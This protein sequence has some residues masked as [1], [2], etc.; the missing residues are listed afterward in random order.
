MSVSIILIGIVCF[1]LFYGKIT[2]MPFVL[3]IFVLGIVFS[4]F[5]KKH[6]HHDAFLAIDCFAQNSKLNAYHPALKMCVAVGYIFLSIA[7]NSLLVSVFLMVTMTALTIYT[8]RMSLHHYV[9]IF[10]IPITFIL[11]SA[12]AILLEI[13]PHP[14]GVLNISVGQ[15][16]FCVTQASQTKALLMIC[17]AFGA[18]SCLYMLCLST[19]MYQIINVLRR[20]KLP[21]VVVE[22]M[23]LIYR[24]IFVLLETQNHMR[25]A[26]ESR[27]GYRNYHTSI[28]TMLNSSMNLLFLSFRRSSDCF[29]AMESR[30]YDGDIV[31]WEEKSH[32]RKQEVLVVSAY[33]MVL[34]TLCILS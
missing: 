7:A 2:V 9:S 22:L 3:L 27:L 11:L 10:M 31:F 19:P 1:L 33:S 20:A 15:W 5:Q 28:K 26:A 18:V 32:I 14:F 16:Y 8:G 34:L 29:A 4:F 21:K 13:S 25:N 6:H 12:L 17:K 30:C 24:Y 23:Y